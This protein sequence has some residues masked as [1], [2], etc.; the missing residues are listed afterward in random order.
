MWIQRE[1]QLI[2]RRPEPKAAGLQQ[3]TKVSPTKKTPKNEACA[4]EDQDYL[5]GLELRDT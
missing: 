3:Q 5:P 1:A 2:G 4:C